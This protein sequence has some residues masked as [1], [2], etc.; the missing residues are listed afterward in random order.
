[1]NDFTRR[2]ISILQRIPAGY[3]VTYGQIART[4]GN[5]R[6]ARQVSRILHAMSAK[7]DLPWHRVVNKEGQI[8]FSNSE[9]RQRLEQENIVVSSANTIDLSI[10]QWKIPFDEEE[11]G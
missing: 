2:V 10:Y 9:Q 6:G 7:F 5:P 11:L 3:V 1:M 4:A 8:T